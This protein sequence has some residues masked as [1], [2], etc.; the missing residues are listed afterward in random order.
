METYF[1]LNGI[2][3]VI[4]YQN[5]K[6]DFFKVVDNQLYY[7]TE[8]ELEQVKKIVCAD[9]GPVYKT[10]KLDQILASNVG[11]ERKDQYRNFYAW[12]E[13]II[14]ESVR[15]NFYHNLETLKIEFND[16]K[17]DQANDSNTIV[18]GGYTPFENKI[19]F[20]PESLKNLRNLAQ[21]QQNPQEFYNM[22]FSHDFLHELTHAAS[23]TYSQEGIRSGFD[24][25]PSED[26]NRG[27]TE[28]MT[29]VIA[30]TGIATDPTSNGYFVESCL[31]QQLVAVLGQNVMLESFFGAKGID[32]LKE[33][34]EKLG[35]DNTKASFLFKSI[36]HNFN[37]RHVEE[38]QNI[39]SCI[40]NMIMDYL[41]ETL[42]RTENKEQLLK[43]FEYFLITPEKLAACRKNPEMYEGLQANITR[44][45]SIKN[46]YLNGVKTEGM[47]NFTQE[48]SFDM[49]EH[50]EK[51]Q[52]QQNDLKA[53][54][55][56]LR[57]RIRQEYLNDM[58]DS[59]FVFANFEIN[60]A[61]NEI[62]VSV[63]RRLEGD[64]DALVINEVLPFND[65]LNKNFLVS[66]A[67][68]FADYSPIMNK[69]ISNHTNSSGSATDKC[70]L[71]ANSENF[72]KLT[73]KNADQTTVQEINQ[74]L[75][76]TKHS[77]YDSELQKKEELTK[78]N[79]NVKQK[80]LKKEDKHNAFVNIGSM[81]VYL[82]FVLDIFFIAVVIMYILQHK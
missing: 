4:R 82:D 62:K 12:L 6:T 50:Q 71:E 80:V 18:A 52:E 78:Q 81:A 42:K 64:S 5:N 19:S 47:D 63:T 40:Q 54:Y 2:K 26:S 48:A 14:P 41:E 16:D 13:S 17:I 33:E 32:K 49:Q 3:Y 1:T 65:E 75:E 23:S 79:T 74:T 43:Y 73:V 28:G 7:L 53:R 10:E 72:N 45:N 44:F 56:G 29:E 77:T 34:L 70:D 51:Q 8:E 25:Y 58:D 57:E 36:E 37:L 30:S 31:A 60:E 38:K 35:Y 61:R 55:E 66:C 67:Y 46:Y 69:G 9:Q 76:N 24:K 11:L 68:D 39:L 22:Y 59:I 20:N 15:E 21:S 27:L